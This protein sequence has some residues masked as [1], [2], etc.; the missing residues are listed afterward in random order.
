MKALNIYVLTLAV[1]GL[2][3]A[4]GSGDKKDDEVKVRNVMTVTPENRQESAVKNFSGVVKE[5]STVNLSFR[6]PGQIQSVNN[7]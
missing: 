6:T 1:A 5:N 2:L 3:V 7:A 4:C